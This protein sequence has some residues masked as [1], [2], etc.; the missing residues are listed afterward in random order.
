L[1]CVPVLGSVALFTVVMA[2]AVNPNPQPRSSLRTPSHGATGSRSR[3]LVGL[4][5]SPKKSECRASI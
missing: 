3:S 5:E 1:E 4:G 2:N